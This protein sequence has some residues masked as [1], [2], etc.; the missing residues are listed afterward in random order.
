MWNAI[1]IGNGYDV[2]KLELGRAFYLGGVKISHTH[3]CIGHS[4]ADVLI[5]SLCDA[6][7]GAL[8]LGDIG[9]H[10]PDTDMQYKNKESIFFLKTVVKLIRE[11]KF[12]IGNIDTIVCLEQ[13]KISP[14]IPEMKKALSEVM[15][16]ERENISIKAT[17]SE[18]LG[19][20]GNKEG[21][22]AY[23]VVLLYTL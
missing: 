4:D 19:F 3:G 1:K 5:H 20:V 14:Y 18:G 22:E 6:L 10:F 7:L 8:G 9:H 17:T 11:K 23:S 21:V 13:P 16:I 2:H 15:Q 12:E